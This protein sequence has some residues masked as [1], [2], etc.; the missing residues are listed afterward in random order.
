MRNIVVIEISHANCLF[1]IIYYFY[2][3]YWWGGEGA[4]TSL[5]YVHT[6]IHVRTITII[7]SR[8]VPLNIQ[9]NN[10]IRTKTLAY[11]FPMRVHNFTSVELCDLFHNTT[12]L[13]SMKNI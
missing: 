2:Y 1:I 9:L 6:H 3:Y 12:A 11:A 4:T 7:Y 5:S 10:T 13:T 8:R